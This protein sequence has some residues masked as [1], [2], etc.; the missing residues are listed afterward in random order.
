MPVSGP[1]ASQAFLRAALD[2]A[3]DAIVGID[4]EGN[5]TEFSSAAEEI[6][7]YSR[8]EALGKPLAELIISSTTPLTCSSRWTR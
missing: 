7:G 8:Q 4:H 3:L 6:F 5:V 2:A 1:E